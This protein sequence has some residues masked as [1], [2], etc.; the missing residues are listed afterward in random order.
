MSLY[1]LVRL[2]FL[3]ILRAIHLRVDIL[4]AIYGAI[5]HAM[6]RSTRHLSHRDVAIIIEYHVNPY[7][8]S[9]IMSGIVRYN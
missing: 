2:V 7:F 6:H 9:A 3:Y 1:Y 4:L 5:I 8:Q